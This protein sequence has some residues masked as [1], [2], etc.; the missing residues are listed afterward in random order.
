MS[1]T[2]LEPT[3]QPESQA[4]FGIWAPAVTPL[5]QDLAPDPGRFTAHVRWLLD[6][7]CHG[8]AVFG[9]TGEANSFSVDE[10]IALLDASLEAGIPAERLMVGTGC[11]ALTDSVRLTRHAVDSGCNRV[12]MLPPFYYKG[13]SD[14]ALLA[15]YAAVIDRVGHD[16]LSVFLYH[17]PRLSG[18]AITTGLVE[19]LLASPYA[20]VIKGI[21]DS[22]G[23]PEG[24][25]TFITQFP[26]LAVFPGTETLLLT[27][28]EAGG[29]GCITASANVNAPAI[30]RVYD[31]WSSHDADTAGLQEVISAQRAALQSQ[32]MIPTL[33]RLLA[34]A[35]GDTAWLAMRPP[36]LPTGQGEAA[37]QDAALAAAG[38]TFGA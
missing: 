3:V 36:M 38:F 4:A 35:L 6:N 31:A 10:R 17:F 33:K 14:E 32:P 13:V 7:G 27:G 12:L 1:I 30:R 16:A 19:R 24:T 22:S 20:G 23:D 11:C 28:L 25:R 5:D 15:S 9:T 29:A 8:V 37:E 2:E 26:G 34:Q 18:V 21:K